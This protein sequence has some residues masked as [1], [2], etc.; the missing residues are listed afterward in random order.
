MDSSHGFPSDLMA[1]RELLA[2]DRS[3]M[4][5]MQKKFWKTKQVLIKATGKKEDEHVVAS[6]ADLDSK[7]E[8][9]RSVQTT[10]TELLKVIEKYQQRIT[11]LSQEENHLGLFLRFQ[12]EHDKTKAGSMMDATSKALCASAKMRLA[13]YPPLRRMEQEVET[14]RRRAITDS[15]ETVGR[16]EKARTEYRGALLWMKDVSQELD[17]DT[18]K[19]LE[20][21]RKVQAQVRSTKVQFDKLKNDVC[22]KVD[23]LG[24]SRCNM[25]SHSLATYQT[26]LLHFWEKTAQMMT[27]I[28]D[29]FQGHVQYQFATLKD[30]KDPLEQLTEGQMVENRK[31]SEIQTHLD[32]L[33]S[34]EEEKAGDSTSETVS[35][36]NTDGQTQDGD[37]SQ[38]VSLDSVLRELADL[39][40]V[41]STHDLLLPASLTPHHLLRQFLQ[42]LCPNVTTPPPVGGSG[43]AAETP[44]SDLTALP[45]SGP[46][47]LLSDA[48]QQD[49]DE[50]RERGDLNFLKDLL[51]PGSMGADEFS[52]EWQDAF[53]SFEMTPSQSLATPSSAQVLSH[54][55]PSSPTGFLPSQLLDQSLSSTGWATPPMFQAPPLQPPQAIGQASPSES[56]AK[57]TA[58]AS[59]VSGRDM[60]AWFNLF[61]DLDPLSNPDAIGRRDEDLMNA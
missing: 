3:V 27:S 37:G 53:G 50:E 28:Q 6:D 32:A 15:L 26:T 45:E 39:Q 13:L 17:P 41:V 20:K 21:F 42:P 59:R 22:Q 56:V 18:Y 51:S 8:F 54:S 38:C 12:A 10:C 11:T 36:L 19:Q 7:L 9:F 16:M 55:Q 2:E 57:T 30:L 29:A 49:L 24:A 43:S 48:G 47:D 52:R 4:A 44:G 1:G 25:L 34:L 23:M 40:S 33:I 31:E 46:R 58:N 5:R 60:S 61:A 14:F 35:A